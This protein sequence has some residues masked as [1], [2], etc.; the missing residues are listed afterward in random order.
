[1]G[2]KPTPEQR[3]DNVETLLHLQGTIIN[4]LRDRI[5]EL[6]AAADERCAERA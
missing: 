3:L 1:M 2:P 5:E 6:E 4:E